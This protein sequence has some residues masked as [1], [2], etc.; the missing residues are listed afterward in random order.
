MEHPFLKKRPS[1]YI[2][3]LIIF[4]IGAF[5]IFLR[6]KA[7]FINPSMWHD[8]CALAYSVIHKN[9]SDFAGGLYFSQVAP[10]L[11]MV[12]SKFTTQLFGVSDKIIRLVPFLSSILSI[13]LFYLIIKDYFK[14][15][16]AKVLALLLFAINQPLINYSFEFKQYGVDVF[17]TLLCLYFFS[18][19]DIERAGLKKVLLYALALC[20]IVWFSFVSIFIIAAGIILLFSRDIKGNLKKKFALILPFL[21][22]LIVYLK[23]Y[24]VHTSVDTTMVNY[25]AQNFIK[26]DFSN[27]L[28]L[29]VNNIKYFFYPM[30]F[31]LFGVLLLIFGLVIGLKEKNKIFQLILMTFLL[32]V[33]SSVVKIYPFY[34]RLILFMLPL[35]MIIML[36][37][38]NIISSKKKFKS[39]S[40]LFLTFFAFYQQI[41]ATIY[42]LKTSSFG[43]GEYPRQMLEILNN[44]VKKNDIIFVNSASNIEFEYYKNY[45]DIKNKVIQENIESPSQSEYFSYLNNKLSKGHYYWFYLPYDSKNNPVFKYILDWISDNAKVIKASRVGKSVLLY[46]CIK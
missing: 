9:Y 41:P 6:A 19:F 31:V 34:E 30:T 18:K 46:L 17:C 38:L 44:N 11:F 20:S 8:E 15:K 37:P 2:Y 22:S 42:T 45:F 26:N 4:I 21:M 13:G 32:V 14:N 27:F 5:A 16:I 33:F 23:F 7:F 40:I 24:F 10:P 43:R 25:W 3:Y 29:L 35:F 1:F 39:F 12:L 36:T 28:Y